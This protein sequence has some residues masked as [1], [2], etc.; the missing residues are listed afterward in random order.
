MGPC[1]A[2]TSRRCRTSTSLDVPGEAWAAAI[3]PDGNRVAVG[4]DD[5]SLRLY[6]LPAGRL[7]G[8]VEDAHEAAI[9]RLVFDADGAVL[10]SASHDNSAK[11]WS[12][13]GDG[14]LTLQQTFTGH[15]DSV[16]G[17]AFSPDGKTLATASYRRAGRSVQ[18][19]GQG[20]GTIH[21][22]SRGEGGAR[23]RSMPAAPGF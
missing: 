7:V 8:E 12:V 20:R 9:N 10:A 15:S 17:V 13:G 14:E 21:R 19:R 2:G 22:C 3:A 16:Y 4:F 1:G 11:L 5:G 6:T 18:G 23:S